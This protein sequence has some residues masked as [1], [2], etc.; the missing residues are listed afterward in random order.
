MSEHQRDPLLMP[1]Q[2]AKRLGVHRDT[3]WR[4]IK[5]GIV[6]IERVGPYKKIRIRASVVDSLAQRGASA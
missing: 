3:M 5:K 1:S 6:E 4:W 2:A